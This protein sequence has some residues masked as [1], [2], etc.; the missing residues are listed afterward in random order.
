MLTY[1]VM[2]VSITDGNNLLHNHA[3]AP[4]ERVNAVLGQRIATLKGVFENMFQDP[5][6]EVVFN[7]CHRSFLSLW[8]YANPLRNENKKELCDIL[9]IYEPHIL[10]F[11]VKNVTLRTHGDKNSALTRW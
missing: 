7:L 5:T 2:S 1:L 6:E 4:D 8:T 11:S 9:A 10:I 3:V